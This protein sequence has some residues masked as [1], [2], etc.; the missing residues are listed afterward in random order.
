MRPLDLRYALGAALSSLVIRAGV[1][2]G[3]TPLAARN[4]VLRHLDDAGASGPGH[5]PEDCPLASHLRRETGLRILLTPARAVATGGRVRGVLVRGVVD[6]PGCVAAAV[7]RVDDT[8]G[9]C[10]GGRAVA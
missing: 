7:A 9:L 3:A 2:P 5:D 10:V 8:D 1:R 4:A 6:L